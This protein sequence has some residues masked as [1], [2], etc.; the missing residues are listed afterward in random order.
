MFHIVLK[1]SVVSSL[2]NDD[3]NDKLAKV[4]SELPQRVLWRLKG[5][6]P[7]TLGNNTL[8][9]DWLPQE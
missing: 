6:R 5:T 7:R 1:G 2:M 9:S 4:F 3:L 8:V